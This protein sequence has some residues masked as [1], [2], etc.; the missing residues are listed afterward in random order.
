M[1][2]PTTDAVYVTAIARYVD[3]VVDAVKAFHKMAEWPKESRDDAP[4]L[5]KL[6]LAYDAAVAELMESTDSYADRKAIKDMIDGMSKT[7]TSALLLMRE[8][9]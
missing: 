9:P 3:T 4:I 8:T 2:H 7:A 1:L 5:R 6:K